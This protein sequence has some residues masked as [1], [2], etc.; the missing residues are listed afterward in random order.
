MDTMQHDMRVACIELVNELQSSQG[1]LAQMLSKDLLPLRE[2]AWA[3]A[4]LLTT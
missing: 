3:K 4:Q 1:K 2:W